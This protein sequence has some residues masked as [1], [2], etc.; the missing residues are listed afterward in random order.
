MS[1][2]DFSNAQLPAL[3]PLEASWATDDVERDLKQLLIDLFREKLAS[4]VFDINVLGA[5]HLGS[6]DLV[7]KIVNLD[8]LSVVDTGNLESATRYLYRAWRS[9]NKQGR[10][11]HFIRTYMQLLFA[12]VSDIRQLWQHKYSP[13]PELLYESEEPD[14]FLTSR[15]R[16][17]FSPDSNLSADSVARIHK[18]IASCAPA[19]F[20]VSLSYDAQLSKSGLQI[21]SIGTF[22][23]ISNTSG[24]TEG[25]LDFGFSSG[26]QVASA[27]HGSNRLTSQGVLN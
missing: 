26:L 15:F 8:G 16:L 1:D 13:Y 19:R 6:F 12:G 22:T 27:G 18:S 24:V 9:G 7:Q 2:F 17:Y 25:K 21:T 11:T 20:V 10:G 5:S 4:E 23:T 3:R 14:C